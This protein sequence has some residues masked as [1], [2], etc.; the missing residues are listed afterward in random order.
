MI[1][2]HHIGL[3][4]VASCALVADLRAQEAASVNGKLTDKSSLQLA[5]ASTRPSESSDQYTGVYV[6]TAG[7]ELI[8]VADDRTLSIERADGSEAPMRLT[9]DAERGSFTSGSLRVIFAR[10]DDGDI[11]GLRFSVL[12]AF[13]ITAEKAPTRRGVVIIQDVTDT[14]EEELPPSVLPELRLPGDLP[15]WTIPFAHLN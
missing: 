5:I 12:G 1:R 11:T 7:I 6:T 9:P 15:S 14:A 8:V 3:C 10:S 2:I 13:G 4:L